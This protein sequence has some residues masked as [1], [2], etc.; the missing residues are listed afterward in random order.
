MMTETREELEEAVRSMIEE[1]RTGVGPEPSEEELLA[2]HR[3][4]LS[5]SETDRFEE[6]LAHYPD[7]ARLLAAFTSETEPNPGDPDHVTDDREAEAWRKL[8]ERL[9]EPRQ[10]PVAAAALH[11]ASAEPPLRPK[12]PAPRPRIPILPWI[13]RVAAATLVLLL[14]I[15]WYSR[16]ERI[17]DLSR[18]VTRLS[19]PQI[20]SEQRLFTPEV[21]DRGTAEERIVHLPHRDHP[22]VL[23]LALSGASDFSSYRLEI[24]PLETPKAEPLW[25][26]SGLERQP[27]DTVSLVLP[28]AFLPSGKYELRL[29][30]LG[31]QSEELVASYEVE[32]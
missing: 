22:Y 31:E 8:K 17:E 2:Y 26:R 20:N 10:Q 1:G 9:V 14:G 29:Y 19:E 18:Q 28:G 23:V 4:E 3:R 32:V 24:V 6:R 7:A 30:G 15:L 27:G 12:P 25:M 21:R 11:P 13:V 16:G 5:P